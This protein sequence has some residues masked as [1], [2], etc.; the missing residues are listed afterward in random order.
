MGSKAPQPPPPEYQVGDI[1]IAAVDI[2][3]LGSGVFPRE[4]IAA[5]GDY[6]RIWKVGGIWP[7]SVSHVQQSRHQA[8]SVEPGEITK[9]PRPT[10]PPPPRKP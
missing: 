9:P 8:F 6:L 10:S 5:K 7:M 1:V 3:S 2:L 4:V